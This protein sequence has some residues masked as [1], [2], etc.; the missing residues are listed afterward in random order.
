MVVRCHWEMKAVQAGAAGLP[1]PGSFPRW[2]NT[3]GQGYGQGTPH[4]L[5][6]TLPGQPALPGV[7]EG[8]FSQRW[9]WLGSEKWLLC[10]G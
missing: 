6:G 9:G 7:S 4:S 5:W 1:G 8:R 3:E 2:Q 10:C